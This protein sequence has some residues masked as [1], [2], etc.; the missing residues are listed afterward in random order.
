M[1]RGGIPCKETTQGARRWY[2]G[3]C[4]PCVIYNVRRQE[5]L[6]PGQGA[7]AAGSPGHVR[8]HTPHHPAPDLVLFCRSLALWHHF[9]SVYCNSCIEVPLTFVAHIYSRQPDRK[10]GWIST[11]KMTTAIKAVDRPIPQQAPPGP[12]Y[13]LPRAPP[14]ASGPRQPQTCLLSRQL[15]WHFLEFSSNGMDPGQPFSLWLLVVGLATLRF[16]YV[17]HASVFHSFSLLSD[18]LLCGCT[19]ICLSLPRWSWWHIWLI[20]LLGSPAI[21]NEAVKNISVLVFHFSWVNT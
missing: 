1:W 13:A 21:V 3:G 14:T 11:H 19:T 10:V 8:G 20:V 17:L 7:G 4:P 18:I 6:E 16:I 2:A 15:S 5:G 9:F 12:P